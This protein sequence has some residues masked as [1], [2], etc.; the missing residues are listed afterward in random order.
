M[1]KFKLNKLVAVSLLALLTQGSAVLS[2]EDDKASFIEVPARLRD[3]ASAMGKLEA[4]ASSDSNANIYFQKARQAELS[5]GFPAVQRVFEEYKSSFT[6]KAASQEERAQ[7]ER[8]AEEHREVTKALEES[9]QK[10]Q[11][12]EQ[13]KV[14]AEQALATV[15]GLDLE[16]VKTLLE[17][18][19]STIHGCN[20]SLFMLKFAGDEL[21]GYEEKLTRILKMTEVSTKTKRDSEKDKNIPKLDIF[22]QLPSSQTKLDPLY[23]Q[24]K[25]EQAPLVFNFG[26]RIEQFERLVNQIKLGIEKIS[27]DP[28][29][30]ATETDIQ[31]FEKYWLNDNKTENEDYKKIFD[32]AQWLITFYKKLIGLLEQQYQRPIDFKKKYDLLFKENAEMLSADFSGVIGGDVLKGDI[33]NM[34]PKVNAPQFLLLGRSGLSLYH[35]V[36]LRK[37]TVSQELQ[38]YLEQLME[39]INKMRIEAF[40]LK[41]QLLEKSSEVFMKSDESDDNL[42]IEPK[43]MKDLLCYIDEYQRTMEKNSLH[44]N[45]KQFMI[46]GNTKYTDFD[47][48]KEYKNANSKSENLILNRMKKS[49]EEWEKFFNEKIDFYESTKAKALKGIFLSKL[50]SGD[51]KLKEKL[52]DITRAGEER[53]AKS[54]AMS[55][56][57]RALSD[58]VQK[59]FK[60]LETDAQANFQL[61]FNEPIAVQEARKRRNRE[62]E[63]YNSNP[64]NT[65]KRTL[66]IAPPL[67]LER[68]NIGTLIRLF[69][70]SHEN[71]SFDDFWSDELSNNESE[72]YTFMQSLLKSD[73]QAKVKEICKATF[74]FVK[75]NTEEEK[76]L[77]TLFDRVIEA[78]KHHKVFME[79]MEKVKNN[80]D[81]SLRDNIPHFGLDQQPMRNKVNQLLSLLD[82]EPD[83]YLKLNPKDRATQI[84]YNFPMFFESA[85][86]PIDEDNPKMKVW[87][88][89][90]DKEFD[91]ALKEAHTAYVKARDTIQA[92]NPSANENNVGAIRL[93]G[94]YVV[95]KPVLQFLPQLQQQEV[96]PMREQ[97]GGP[98]LRP[99]MLPPIPG[100]RGGP[101]L[102]P[103]MLP[104][105]PG[106]RGGLRGG[107]GGPAAL[108]RGGNPGMSA[109]T[110]PEEVQ[111][112]EA[113]DAYYGEIV[114]LL[115]QQHTVI[116]DTFS[117]LFEDIY[118]KY[119]ETKNN[120]QDDR[121]SREVAVKERR[122]KKL[123]EFIASLTSNL[124][125]EAITEVIKNLIQNSG[126]QYIDNSRPDIKTILNS[127]IAS[128]KSFNIEE[129][130]EGIFDKELV[131]FKK[132]ELENA[133]RLERRMER[134]ASYEQK[135]NGFVMPTLK[136]ASI[137]EPKKV[138]V[139]KIVKI[140]SEITEIQPAD[141]T[142]QA[143]FDVNQKRLAKIKD[144]LE[145]EKGIDFTKGFADAELLAF[146]MWAIIELEAED[147]EDLREGFQ[148]DGFSNRK[149]SLGVLDY[150]STV[151]FNKNEEERIKSQLLTAKVIKKETQKYVLTSILQAS[152]QTMEKLYS[153]IK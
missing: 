70:D 3:L 51:T 103:D 90:D 22:L 59:Q 1:I 137:D 53:A 7:T 133:L 38:G 77:Y 2:M 49:I 109:Q 139:E 95:N 71:S 145:I 66:E 5:G 105:I 30:K 80:F 68:T 104:P 35:Y 25:D 10:I 65:V 121:Q 46:Q 67:T 27:K 20:D 44:K 61:L 58:L 73:S 45:M 129:R 64:K 13:E 141:S 136:K 97:K 17:N 88:E 8:L 4:L 34:G 132:K 32:S 6:A 54:L 124:A 130:L 122:V 43:E 40:Q 72:V 114:E 108:L 93:G 83:A 16:K 84:A 101:V 26:G 118:K 15:S 63:E 89:A 21:P 48:M 31:Y 87:G 18:F 143:I 148:V 39:N 82:G 107:R 47:K 110:M 146:P 116:S 126:Y 57:D 75:A 19:S 147:L 117:S 134:S 99:D 52:D 11:Q 50:Y 69:I 102:R 128:K 112:K 79:A 41:S 123:E 28:E 140:E 74:D 23:K 36:R 56:Y 62:I 127:V 60:K 153:G 142:P 86:K 55:A 119:I 33:P 115:L 98:V 131:K 91:E 149:F 113:C 120:V 12:V 14:V 96:L 92:I 24:F 150:I 42:T 138:E 135:G 106:Q 29:L 144:I 78:Q 37:D 94:F 125:Q 81:L 100:Q 111:V 85:L 152:R 9:K 151:R 76:Q